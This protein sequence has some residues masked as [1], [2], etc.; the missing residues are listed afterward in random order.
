MNNTSLARVSVRTLLQHNESTNIVQIMYPCNNY[1]CAD[2]YCT[3]DSIFCT[4]LYFGVF[5]D[6]IY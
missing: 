1:V 6:V 3:K 2:K 5:Y 4:A